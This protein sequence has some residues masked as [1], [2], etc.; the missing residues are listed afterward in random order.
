MTGDQIFILADIA[1]DVLKL[2]AIV[3]IGVL[4]LIFRKG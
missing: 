1:L 3:C 2:Y 4:I